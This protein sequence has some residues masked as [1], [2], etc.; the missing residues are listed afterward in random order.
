MKAARIAVA[1]LAVLALAGCGET[2]ADVQRDGKFKHAC[3]AAGGSVWSPTGSGPWS[4]DMTTK[5]D[6]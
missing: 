6:K 4:C 1:L 3:E 5:G 2:V